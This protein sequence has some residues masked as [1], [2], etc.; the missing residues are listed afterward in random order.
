M[1]VRVLLGTAIADQFFEVQ[2]KVG[3]IEIGIGIEIE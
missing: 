1:R 3:A 2:S